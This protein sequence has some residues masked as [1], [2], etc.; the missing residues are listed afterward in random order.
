[1]NRQILKFEC[2]SFH[3]LLRY[4]C[5]AFVSLSQPTVIQGRQW[6]GNYRYSLAYTDTTTSQGS[7]F[8]VPSLHGRV[9]L[10]SV[11]KQHKLKV[12]IIP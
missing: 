5:F 9:L 6:I 12:S 2:T 8:K 3:R 1:M 7:R 11:A 10:Q 4:I